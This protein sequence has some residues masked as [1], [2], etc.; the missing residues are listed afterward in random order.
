MTYLAPIKP[1]MLCL[2]MAGCMGTSPQIGY[3]LMT[4]E[5]LDVDGAVF[6]IFIH[7]DRTRVEAHRINMIYPPPS[8]IEILE[9]AHRAILQATGC[10]VADNTL[11]GDQAIIKAELECGT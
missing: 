4:P 2:L 8:R 10:K 11:V 1:F 7:A 3:T 5:P 6:K 9:K